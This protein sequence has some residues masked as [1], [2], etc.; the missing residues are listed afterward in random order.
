VLFQYAR[1]FM[2]ERRVAELAARYAAGDNIGDGAIKAEVADA[3]D[4]LLAPM[5]ERRARYTDADVL[6][7][8]RA[9]T[10]RAN[11]FAQDALARAKA[12]MKLDFT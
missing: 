10:R 11:A 4:A 8:L 6:E 3:I 9:H 7:I 2:P 1:A 12:A 5:R